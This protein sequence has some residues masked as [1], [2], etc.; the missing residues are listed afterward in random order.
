M[1]AFYPI[2]RGAGSPTDTIIGEI[3]FSAG[4]VHD[5]SGMFALGCSHAGESF[6]SEQGH[7]ERWLL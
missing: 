6:V 1:G 4:D 3:S 2:P 5:S 7:D